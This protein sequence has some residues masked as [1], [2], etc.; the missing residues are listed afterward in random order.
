MQKPLK[1]MAKPGCPV[2]KEEESEKIQRE[3]G[4]AQIQRF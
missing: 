3:R 1:L 2:V 4:L